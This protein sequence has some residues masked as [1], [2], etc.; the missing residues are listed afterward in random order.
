MFV[1]GLA[2]C[3]ALKLNAQGPCKEVIG[4]Y[5]NWQ[6]YDRG[7]LVNP[8]SI[9]YSRYTI[10]N[11]S[12]FDV[13]SDGSLQTLD[14][15]ADKNLLLG[16]IN[17]SVAPAGY[18][19]S[20]DFGNADYHHP[21][22][23][24]SDYC[25]TAG[26]KLLPSLGGWTLSFNFPAIAADP[27]KR[28]T[29]AHSCVELIEAFNFD[30]IDIDWEYPGYAPHGGTPADKENFTLLLAEVRQALDLAEIDL[31]K[32]LLLTIAVGAAPARMEEVEWEAISELVDIINVMSYDYFGAW[33]PETNHNAPLTAPAAGDPG[34]NV[35]AT[36]DR[37]LNQYAVSPSKVALGLGF[38]GRSVVTTG[39]PGLHVPSSGSADGATFSA[40]EGSPLY[41]NILAAESLFEK[42]WDELAQ[43]PYLTGLNG[44]QT[45]VS[46]DD[47]LSISL[48]ASYAVEQNLR[49]VIIWEI[50]GDYVETA[51]GS[52]IIAG[53]PL[54]D[55]LNDALCS[56]AQEPVCLGDYDNDG[57]VTVSDLLLLLAEFGCVQSCTADLDGN[58]GVTTS[59]V[60]IFLSVFGNECN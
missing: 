20:F 4:Y 9:D 27:I 19:S 17:W 24:F 22:Q 12:F 54:A 46:Y 28:Q 35:A 47:S 26:V 39:A 32:E 49:G 43:V 58:Q 7:N 59:D 44:L 11:Y 37:L 42:H 57:F 48:K 18:E 56:E 5:P 40:D 45:F 36:I 50:T 34:F 13:L 33:D 8:E 2:F 30:G 29:F 14:P 3:M 21:G 25:Q 38:Y 10:I 1:L 41:Y 52:G 16:P 31:G 23:A 6:W 15:W 53:T 60:L 51:L 55:A